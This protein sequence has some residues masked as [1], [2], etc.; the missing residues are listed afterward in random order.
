MNGL[1]DSFPVDGLHIGVGAGVGLISQE[2]F[3]YAM[4]GDPNGH[5]GL[6]AIPAVVAAMGATALAALFVPAARLPIAAGYATAYGRVWWVNR[7]P[8]TRV[9]PTPSLEGCPHY[10]VGTSARSLMGLGAQV[11]AD[12][13]QPL[14]PEQQEAG[15]NWTAHQRQPCRCLTDALR[16]YE[17]FRQMVTEE[18]DGAMTPEVSAGWLYMQCVDVGA[19]QTTQSM[20]ERFPDFNFNASCTSSDNAVADTTGS[21][22]WYWALGALA[23][24]G[25]G[26]YLW[27]R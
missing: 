2:A 25:V 10:K 3:S 15:A 22:S 8:P 18:S 21:S 6:E 11:G 14:T 13:V 9:P 23:V 7:N 12:T 19:E 20:L 4:T 1:A 26:I 5:M 24:A 17:P 16:Q 27:R